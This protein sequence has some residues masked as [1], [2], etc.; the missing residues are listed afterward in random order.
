MRAFPQS[1]NPNNRNAVFD[2]GSVKRSDSGSKNYYMV[3]S[4][5]E[6]PRDL[7]ASGC[8]SSADRRVL[9][10][11]EQKSHAKTPSL[12]AAEPQPKQNLTQR[13]KEAKKRRDVK[14]L[15]KRERFSEMALQR[16]EPEDQQKVT[17]DTKTDKT[18]STFAEVPLCD[19]CDLL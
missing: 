15:P 4:L 19:L 18:T 13:R 9:V 5:G 14:N 16:F 6:G 1:P 17:K 11:D 10:I 8:R 7:L 12:S 3:T 2:D